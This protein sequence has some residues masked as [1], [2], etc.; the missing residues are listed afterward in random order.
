[1]GRVTNGFFSNCSNFK[2]KGVDYF[3][4]S[5]LNRNFETAAR[6]INDKKEAE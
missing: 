4:V 5:C 2:D 1:V 6:L 3:Y